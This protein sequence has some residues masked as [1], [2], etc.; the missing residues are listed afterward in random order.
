MT[1]TEDMARLF[2]RADASMTEQKKVGH[3]MRGV[4]QEIFAGLVRNPPATLTDFLT[5]ATAMERALRER[6][7]Q[8]NRSVLELS[9]GTPACSNI[10]DLRELISVVIREELQKMRS[11][12]AP[13]PRIS[14]VENLR[15][16]IRQAVQVPGYEVPNRSEIP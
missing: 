11:T 15:D 12:D 3:L 10:E 16:E 5:E 13:T 2:R 7:R 6:T 4:K 8:Y 14:V 1:Y 9:H